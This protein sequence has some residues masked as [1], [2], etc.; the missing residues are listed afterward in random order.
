[1]TEISNTLPYHIA[2]IPDGNRRWAKNKMIPSIL[3]HKKGFDRAMEIIDTCYD[4]GIRVVT[5]Y[6]FSTENWN[7]AKDEV[8]Y[9]AKLFVNF[10]DKNIEKFRK[11]GIRLIH[12][13]EISRFSPD[14]QDRIQKGVK[15]TAGN[16]KMTVQ[17]AL[18][19]GGRDEITRAMQSIVKK[20]I[21]AED[22]N[23]ETIRSALDSKDIPDPDLIIRTSGEQ[24]LSGFLLWQSAYSE[25]YFRDINWP[26]FTKAELKKAITEFQ[27]RQR[28]FG[29]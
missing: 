12:L 10:F 27:H 19:Y 3:G 21:K 1:M 24:R 14:F 20:G 26:D 11:K 13:G 18:N 8:D 17:L 4:H 23:E 7:R 25:L 9:L 16:S 22:I 29:K 5:L 28:R 6:G 2:I 15:N